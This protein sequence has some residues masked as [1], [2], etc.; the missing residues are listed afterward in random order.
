MNFARRLYK[1]LIYSLIYLYYLATIIHSN[2]VYSLI[3]LPYITTKHLIM[4]LDNPD[5]N[6]VQGIFIVDFEK[7]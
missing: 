7:T 1:V 3:E 5:K 4:T 2:K 6:Q